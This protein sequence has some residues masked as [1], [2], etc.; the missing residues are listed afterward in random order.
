MRP[1]SRGNVRLSG[2]GFRRAADDDDTLGAF[3]K[4]AFQSYF[5]P[6]GTCAMGDTDMSVVDS[7]LRVHGIVGLRVADASVMPSIPSATP[8][9]RSTRSPSGR[10][11]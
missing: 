5:H 6:V 10:P 9:R 3:A 7:E 1:F 11:R 2:A 8:P 4:A